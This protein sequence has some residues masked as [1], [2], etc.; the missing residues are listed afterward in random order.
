MLAQFLAL[1]VSSDGRGMV[2]FPA[3]G[4]FIAGKDIVRRRMYEFGAQF[5]A[6]RRQVHRQ[7]GVGLHRRI[8]FRFAGVYVGHRRAVDDKI[9][10]YRLHAGP[11]LGQV[12]KI[13]RIHVLIKHLCMLVG[14]VDGADFRAP[15]F[16]HALEFIA[17]LPMGAGDEGSSCRS[18]LI[19]PCPLPGTGI[20]RSPSFS[21]FPPGSKAARG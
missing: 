19:F 13:H 4:I 20:G 2:P 12:G 7:D 5:L 8:Q 1:A 6:Q 18:L 16:Q 17:Q 10:L 14:R 9:R 21:A 11:C 15:A 3:G